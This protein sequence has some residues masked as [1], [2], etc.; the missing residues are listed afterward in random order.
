MNTRKLALVGVALFG[1]AACAAGS[2]ASHQAAQ[3]G[4]LSEIMLGVWQGLIAPFT[5]IGEIV[6]SVAPRVL[7]WTFRV[8]E[9]NG[10]GVLYDVGFVLGLII[11]P[12]FLWMRAARRA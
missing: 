9:P 10:T 4:A 12:S 3:G 2:A 7:P 11:G 8:Y 5:L 6:Q 1:L